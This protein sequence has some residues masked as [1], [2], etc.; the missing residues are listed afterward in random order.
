MS[1]CID[2][3][4]TDYKIYRRKV[5][6]ELDALTLQNLLLGM[7]PGK[8]ER[9]MRFQVHTQKTQMTYSSLRPEVLDLAINVSDAMGPSLDTNA[10]AS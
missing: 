5:G 1:G 7:L 10:L 6:R 9:Q 2:A 4:E 3:F 8:W